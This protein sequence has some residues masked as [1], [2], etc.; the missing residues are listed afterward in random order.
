MSMLMDVD[1]AMLIRRLM[2]VDGAN[3]APSREVS[4]WDCGFE[5]VHES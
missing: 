1:M 3:L 4:K 5:V 2:I